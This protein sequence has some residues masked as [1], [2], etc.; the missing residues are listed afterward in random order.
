MKARLLMLTTALM[1]TAV[2]RGN[3]LDLVEI[4]VSGHFFSEPA[5]VRLL[6]TVEPDRANRTLRIEADGDRL[7]RSTEVNL[8]GLSEKRLHTVEFK[9][10]PA[11]A[12]HVRAEVFSASEIRGMATE[13]L[14]VLGAGSREK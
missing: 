2:I 8:D 9:N 5:T 11:G 7:F 1:G 10:L 6:V 12:Y 14:T 3:A 13:E 4:R